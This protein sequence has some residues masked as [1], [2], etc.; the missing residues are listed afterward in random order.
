[1]PRRRIRSWLPGVILVLALLQ[2][3]QPTPPGPVLPGDGPIGNHVDVPPRVDAILR[4]ACY[5]CHSGET[6]WPW[7]AR[8]SPVSWIIAGDIEHGRGNLDFS[9]WST[10]PTREPTQVQ[11]LRWICRDMLEDVMPPRSYRWMHREA[12]LSAQQKDMICVWSQ[13]TRDHLAES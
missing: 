11:R 5:D 10:H 4:T 13:R 12:R 8:V 6:R 9:Q 3:F 2:F 7:Y 1:M